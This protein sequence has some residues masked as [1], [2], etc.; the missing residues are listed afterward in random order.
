MHTGRYQSVPNACDV[1]SNKLFQEI[2]QGK[3]SGVVEADYYEQEYFDRF[4]NDKGEVGHFYSNKQ[5]CRRVSPEWFGQKR[6]NGKALKV[7]LTTYREAGMAAKD[8]KD[9]NPIS[10]SRNITGDAVMAE[11]KIGDF[12]ACSFRVVNSP[13]IS[14]VAGRT[15]VTLTGYGDWAPDSPEEYVRAFTPIAQRVVNEVHEAIE[16]GTRSRVP[17]VHPQ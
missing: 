15:Q 7:D 5:E 16:Q 10:P 12:A 8:A 4:E 2:T 6:R 9:C 3:D 11:E 14:F 1:L 13:T 17:T